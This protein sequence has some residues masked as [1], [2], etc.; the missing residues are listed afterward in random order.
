MIWMVKNKMKELVRQF[1]N[2]GLATTFYLKPI[3]FV[4][5]HIK[6]KKILRLFKVL[7]LVL[8]TT[9]VLS[10]ALYVLLT[11]LSII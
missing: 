2:G 6:N 1:Y 10:F 7:I 3:N 9:T 8:Y 11:K 5:S 4:D